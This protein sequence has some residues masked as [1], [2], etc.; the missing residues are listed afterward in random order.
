[1]NK[2]IKVGDRFIKGSG[3]VITITEICEDGYVFFNDNSR[4]YYYEGNTIVFTMVKGGDMINIKPFII[5]DGK[6][7]LTYDGDELEFK[8][9]Q[10]DPDDF[11][12][13]VSDEGTEYSSD[14]QYV[15]D[16]PEI[17]KDLNIAGLNNDYVKSVLNERNFKQSDFVDVKVSEME[18]IPPNSNPYL[19]DTNNSGMYLINGWEV[20]FSSS[21]PA[22]LKELILI[23]MF[24]GQQ[25]KLDLT[26][27]KT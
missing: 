19:F 2:Q 18:S 11:A 1:M 12:I 23:N 20:M 27:R 14:G 22:P 26:K 16:G 6:V 21:Q 15:V 7:Y 4:L 5:E 10:N 8:V 13:Y 25:I 9:I 24:S 3:L 17:L